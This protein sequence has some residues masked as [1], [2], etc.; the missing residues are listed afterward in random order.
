MSETNEQRARVFVGTLKVNVDNANLD[1]K[2]FRQFVRN[3]LTQFDDKPASPQGDDHIGPY[4]SGV[5]QND[6]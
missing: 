4:G 5:D 1:D 6:R 3:S 2:A